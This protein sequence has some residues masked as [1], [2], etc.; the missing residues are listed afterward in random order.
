[1]VSPE[2]DLG[3]SVSPVSNR[4]IV[5]KDA[6][7]EFLLEGVFR[8]G[9][10]IDFDAQAGFFMGLYE[11]GIVI[12]GMR[13]LDDFVAPRHVRIHRFA[14]NET[15]LGKPELQCCRSADRALRVMRSKGYLARFRKSTNFSCRGKPA[16][17]RNI[18]L[19]N[20]TP[21]GSKQIPELAQIR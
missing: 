15:G 2:M 19:A 21:S 8:N 10:L 4:A 20:A 9:L 13:K 1:M 5:I 14:Y 18:G 16:A 11:A 12:D 6:L 17:M 3:M 7:Q